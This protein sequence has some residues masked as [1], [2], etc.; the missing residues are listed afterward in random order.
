MNLFSQEE[1]DFM[2]AVDANPQAFVELRICCEEGEE[3]T[4]FFSTYAKADKWRDN[5]PGAYAAIYVPH[6]LNEPDWG[7]VKRQ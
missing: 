3:H 4:G 1:R 6:M 5:F 2:A 7:N